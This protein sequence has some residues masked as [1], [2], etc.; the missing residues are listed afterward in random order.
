MSIKKRG[1]ESPRGRLNLSELE[2]IH[3]PLPKLEVADIILVR[4][5]K[6]VMRRLLRRVTQSYWDHT[7][8]IIYPF[9]ATKGYSNNIYIESIQYGINSSLKRGVEIHRLEKYLNNPARYDIG[10][11]RFSWL[12]PSIKSRVRSYMLMN[13]DTPYYPLATSKFLLALFSDFYK[14]N[15]LRRQRYSC[16]GLVQKSFYEAVDWKDRADIVFK[17]PG[18]T[19]IEIQETTSPADIAESDACDWIWNKH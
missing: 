16:S 19:P 18:Y 10:I 8:M 11:K 9:D 3:G 7:A 4:H 1:N 5:K 13:I 6:G 17:G 2:K 15:L 14:K 12:S